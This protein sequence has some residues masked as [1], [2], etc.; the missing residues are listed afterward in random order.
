MESQE[1]RKFLDEA[2]ERPLSP[3]SHEHVQHCD[4]CRDMDRTLLAL[5]EEKTLYHGPEVLALKAKEM[6]TCLPPTPPPTTPTVPVQPAAVSMTAPKDQETLVQTEAD[7]KTVAL[8]SGGTV[9]IAP[10][11]C[12][13]PTEQGFELFWGQVVCTTADQQKSSAVVVTRFGQVRLTG[14][15]ATIE[16]GQD[17]LAVT[18]HRGQ[19]Q[20]LDREARVHPIG[21]GKKQILGT[22][23]APAPLNVPKH[24]VLPTDTE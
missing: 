18:V 14:G 1:C 24:T 21:V 15:S 6:Q 5:R 2:V 10:H 3:A 4:E 19:A 13:R 17:A 22:T 12:G 9:Q 11:S 23:N 7:P 20:F 8:P 16:P